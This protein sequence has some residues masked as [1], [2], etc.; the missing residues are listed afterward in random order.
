MDMIMVVQSFLVRGH[1]IPCSTI[2]PSTDNERYYRD[3]VVVIV[4]ELQ[5]VAREPQETRERYL[6]KIIFR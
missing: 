3:N 4:Q 5:L 1:D 6:Y 2:L